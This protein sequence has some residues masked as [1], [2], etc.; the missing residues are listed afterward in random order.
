MVEIVS[1]AINFLMTN[2]FTTFTPVLDNFIASSL[3]ETL[4]NLVHVK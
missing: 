3:P 2:I 4:Q 1:L